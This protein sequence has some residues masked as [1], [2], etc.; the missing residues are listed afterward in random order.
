M[1]VT[2]T[3]LSK[4]LNP[5]QTF[6]NNFHPFVPFFSEQ[7]VP[8]IMFF[9][10]CALKV[11]HFQQ[12]SVFCGVKSDTIFSTLIHSPK[13]SQTCFFINWRGTFLS[14]KHTPTPDQ[15]CESGCLCTALF[16]FFCLIVIDNSC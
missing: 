2:K 5:R 3:H 15:L 10:T 4:N 9:L 11:K 7:P 14:V 16:S 12:L 8:G 13:Q 1:Q 6:S